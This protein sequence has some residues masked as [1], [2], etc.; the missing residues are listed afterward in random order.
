MTHFYKQ[1]KTS[2]KI[3]LQIW[4]YE[5]GK[6]IFVE[7]LGTADKLVTKLTQLRTAVDQTKEKLKKET[8]K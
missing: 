7:S 6:K 3:Y 4:K 5:K 1:N 2:G 8:K